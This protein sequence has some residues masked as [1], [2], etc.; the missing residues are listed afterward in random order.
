MTED[1]SFFFFFS[2]GECFNYRVASSLTTSVQMS[3]SEFAAC[4]EYGFSK[5]E[6]KKYIVFIVTGQGSVLQHPYISGFSQLHFFF[7][8]ISDTSCRLSLFMLA[9]TF[10]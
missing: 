3:A 2:L 7:F 8:S 10:L 5:K 6:K 1:S 9:I 4:V